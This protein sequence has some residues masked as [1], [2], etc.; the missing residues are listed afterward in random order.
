MF[1]TYVLAR[2]VLLMLTWFEFLL[3]PIKMLMLK[4]F[5]DKSM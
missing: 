4:R 5:L 1:S 2:E 3:C